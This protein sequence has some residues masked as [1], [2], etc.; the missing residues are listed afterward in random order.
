M[1][2]NMANE[3]NKQINAELYSAYLYQAMS[4]FCG[5]QNLKG[6]ERW[7]QAQALEE[8]SHAMKFYGYLMDKG[9][10]VVLEAVDKPKSEW[11]SLLEVFEDAYKHEQKV[12]GL[13]NNLM[14]VA[15]KDADY[16][17]EIMLQW[18]VTEQIEEEKDASEIAAKLKLIGDSVQGLFMMDAHLGS[19]KIPESIL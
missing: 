1:T 3:L 9:E 7:F 5:S 19:R 13:I 4:S 10:K 2:Q 15:K 12:T 16:Q 8:M 18:F 11:K 17:T 6:A 14:T